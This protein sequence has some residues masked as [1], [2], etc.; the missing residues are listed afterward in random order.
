M[1]YVNRVKKIAILNNKIMEI[2]KDDEEIEISRLA[3]L[4]SYS[5]H[6]FKYTILK[7]ILALNKC[8]EIT[9]SDMLR[10]KKDCS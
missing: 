1:I 5:Y 10:V 7:E 4:L 3:L 8:L 6:H 2:L 9:E